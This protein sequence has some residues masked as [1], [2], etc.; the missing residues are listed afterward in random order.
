MESTI[1][2]GDLDADARDAILSCHFVVQTATTTSVRCVPEDPIVS[3]IATHQSTYRA[4]ET[5]MLG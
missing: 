2:I 5:G 3:A 1:G 4:K